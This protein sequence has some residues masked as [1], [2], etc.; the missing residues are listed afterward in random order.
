MRSTPDAAENA[1]ARRR[2]LARVV[3]FSTGRISVQG[4]LPRCS[5][6]EPSVAG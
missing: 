5:G 1:A 2:S 6:R 3:A 4:R